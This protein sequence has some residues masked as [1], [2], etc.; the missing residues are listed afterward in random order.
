MLHSTGMGLFVRHAKWLWLGWILAA[1]AVL[2]LAVESAAGRWLPAARAAQG[3]AVIYVDDSAVRGANDGSSWANAFLDLQDA[4]NLAQAGDEIR[5][6]QGTYK[7]APPGGDRTIS[8][9]LVSGVTMQGGYAG[10]GASDPDEL[11]HVAFQT[12]LSG[13]LNSNDAPPFQNTGE[14]SFHVVI[15]N[16]LDSTTAL[17]GVVITAGFANAEPNCNNAGPNSKGGGFVGVNC[18]MTFE[19]CVI[20]RNRATCEAGGM[21]ITGAPRF[22]RCQFDTNLISQGATE[23]YYGGFAGGGDGGSRIARFTDCVFHN[24]GN[25]WSVGGLAAWNAT[26]VSCSF[27]FNE[28][29]EFVG[30]MS[31]YGV[32]LINCTFDS[33]DSGNWVGCLS[34]GNADIVNCRFT[35]NHAS[36]CLMYPGS[37]I[38]TVD[39]D[40]RIINCN[41]T[42]NLGSPAI[43]IHGTGN[44][45]RNCTIVGNRADCG[46]AGI[47]VA[48]D[49]AI[50]NSILWGNWDFDD[51]DQ[52]SQIHVSSGAISVIN[53]CIQGWTGSLGGTGNHGND[54]RFIDADGPDNIYG[55]ADDNPRLLANSPCIDSGNSTLLPP[56]QFDLDEDGNTTEP[57]PIDLDGLPRVV[58]ASVDMG[59][60]E[61]QG[62]PCRADIDGN[63]SVAVND[64]LAVILVW[65]PCTP[66]QMCN[67]DLDLDG[68]VAVNDLLA[69]ITAWGDC[70]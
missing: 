28:A 7:P 35:R 25:A 39:G 4:L 10:F 8:F 44:A 15:G 21:M 47:Y 36:M 59:A 49:V 48:G 6:G 37:A 26:F 3:G 66:G 54:P 60:Y 43:S 9:N 5:I 38:R 57:L 53:T 56:D 13:D 11:D 46:V 62:A 22:N 16:D 12:F 40:T 19:D 65:G 30:G 41:F 17:R 70:P 24:N 31:A 29:Y 52:G 33:N 14:N 27:T 64:L 32:A 61:F 67:S 45:I 51:F 20:R 23:A 34:V 42:G 2:L 68:Q 58:G 63:G 69:V 55:T 18:D 50:S 1:A